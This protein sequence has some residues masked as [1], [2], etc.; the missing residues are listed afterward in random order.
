MSADEKGSE[1]YRAPAGRGDALYLIKK[2]A[3]AGYM[4]TGAGTEKEFEE[5]WRTAFYV[6]DVDP[7]SED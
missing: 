5:L 7:G 1:P 2:Y 6:E 3:L 4:E